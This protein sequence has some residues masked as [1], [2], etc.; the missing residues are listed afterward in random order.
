MSKLVSIF[1]RR[2]GDQ[3]SYEALLS[4]HISGLYKQAYRYTGSEHEAED[5]LQDVLLEIYQ[6]Q[7]QLRAATAPAAWLHRCLYHRFI[8]SYRKRQRQLDT[9]ADG[10]TL[11]A[12]V[13][14]ADNPEADL[15]YQQIIRAMQALTPAQR[16]V[17]S[18]HD[19]EA[20]TLT[21]LSRTMAMPLGTLKSHLHRGRKVLQQQ[22]SL[23][24]FDNNQRYT[25]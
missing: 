16:M 19:I 3:Q 1:K 22:L 24:P 17:V 12:T 25:Q 10:D 4:P 13:A 15:A 23:Q 9:D 2:S 14:S 6:K 11:L 21:E 7:A 18:L 5:L 20:Y 8:D